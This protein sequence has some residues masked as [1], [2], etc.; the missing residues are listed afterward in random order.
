[1]KKIVGTAFALTLIAFLFNQCNTDG[2]NPVESN[3]PVVNPITNSWTDSSNSEHRFSFTTY[4]S[5]VSRGIFFGFE[6]H[7]DSFAVNT[8][9]LHGFFDKTYVEFD[10]IW[11]HINK[12]VK[13]KGN[14]INNNKMELQSSE[15]RIVLTR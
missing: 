11:T 3:D 15:G 9:E 6:D 12:R 2:N 5:T 7:P 14:F 13:F 10:V 8:P 4:D 1:M